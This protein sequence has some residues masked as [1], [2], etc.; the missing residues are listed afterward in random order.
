MIDKQQMIQ[1]LEDELADVMMKRDVLEQ[2][3]MALES[4]LESLRE[5]VSIN[6]EPPKPTS[7][8]KPL[9]KRNAFANLSITEASIRYLRVLGEKQT[10]RQVVDA[11]LQGG[12][13]LGGKSPADT[14][15]SLLLRENN[16]PNGQVYWDDETKEWGLREWLSAR[17]GED[18]T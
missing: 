18:E 14:V 16:K 1:A 5:L 4:A 6:G 9:F 2:R 3:E 15:R 11:L 17:A 8:N 7:P 13:Q 12:K 10:N